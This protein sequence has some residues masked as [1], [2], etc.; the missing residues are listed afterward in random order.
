LFVFS[1]ENNNNKKPT[2][3]RKITLE[4]VE[5]AWAVLTGEKDQWCLELI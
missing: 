3:A 1:K 5:G 4:L 2:T